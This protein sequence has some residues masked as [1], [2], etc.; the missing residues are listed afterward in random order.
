MIQSREETDLFMD[1]DLR[2]PILSIFPKMK[3]EQARVRTYETLNRHE[4]V[5]A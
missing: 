1:S 2:D 3:I 5:T 4:T